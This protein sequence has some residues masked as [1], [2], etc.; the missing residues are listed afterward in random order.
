MGR[1]KH[2]T[3]RKAARKGPPPKPTTL[4]KRYAVEGF[5][6]VRTDPVTHQRQVLVRWKD[7]PM[8]AST[9]EPYQQLVEDGWGPELAAGLPR[10]ETRSYLLVVRFQNTRT[11]S[12]A[13]YRSLRRLLGKYGGKRSV[14]HMPGNTHIVFSMTEKET[15]AFTQVFR[16]WVAGFKT[17]SCAHAQLFR[18]AE[19]EGH[20]SVYP[21]IR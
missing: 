10:G 18:V 19:D 4:K 12:S 6:G 16:K 2:T 21:P 8:S 9:W 5:C 7:Y 15:V 11:A 13:V 20:L 3:T 1:T 17:L 14:Q